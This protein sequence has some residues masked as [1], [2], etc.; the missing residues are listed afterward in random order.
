[1]GDAENIRRVVEIVKGRACEPLVVVLSAMGHTTDRLKAL[2]EAAVGGRPKD[3]R[4]ILASFR[5]VHLG[6]ALALLPEREARREVEAF[7]AARFETLEGMVR[8]MEALGDLSPAVEDRLLGFGELLSSR[9]MAAVLRQ[10]GIPATWLDARDLIV[11]DGRHRGAVPLEEETR[12]L[13]EDAIPPVLASG[14]VAVTQGY[15]ARSA[16]GTDTTLGR[17]GSDY[18]ASL[19]GAA[20]HADEIEIWTDVDGVMTADP[21]LVHEARSIPAMSFQEAAELAFFG[22]RV[23]HPKTLLPAVQMGIP[24]R[25][26]N[27]RRPAATGTLIMAA[28]PS[29]G[30]AV[31]SVAYKEGMVLVNLVSSRMFKAQGFLGEV[32]GI[33][34]RHRTAPDVMATSEVSAAMAFFPTEGFDAALGELAGL[35]TV[36]ARRRQALVCVV[37]ERLKEAPGMVGRVFSALNDVKVSLVSQ[38]GSEINL[39]FVVDE[40]VL[41]LVVRRLHECFFGASAA[42]EDAGR[43]TT[44]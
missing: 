33:L 20:L 31:K 28:P 17:G 32:F 43:A 15:I 19:I 37:G 11:T 22:A 13:C 25:V 21:T 42:G 24:V 30:H 36:T 27:T 8:G 34:A 44:G 10:E 1:M 16:S 26:L 7:C 12:R 5:A 9:I 4:D 23:L 38:G 3:A 29:N 41:T 35:G 18:T 39:G 6:A 2:G 40:E 14:A